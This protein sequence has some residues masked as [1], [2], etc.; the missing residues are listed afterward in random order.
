MSKFQDMFFNTAADVVSARETERTLEQRTQLGD[1]EATGTREAQSSCTMPGDE[2]REPTRAMRS[3]TAAI[4]RGKTGKDFGSPPSKGDK[5]AP[6]FKRTPTGYGVTRGIDLPPEFG[7]R[8]YSRIDPRKYKYDAVRASTYALNF[9][10][11]RDDRMPVEMACEKL[12]QIRARCGVV[13]GQHDDTTVAAFD[14]ALWFCHTVNSASRLNPGRSTFSVPGCTEEF[15]Y[16]D[17]LQILGEDARRFFRTYADDIA[18][19]NR[20]VLSEYDP[21]DIVATERW[22]WLMDVAVR[23]DITK[24]PYLAHDS[25]EACLHLTLS[26]RAALAASK[27]EVLSKVESRQN[28]LDEVFVRKRDVRA[29]R[30]TENWRKF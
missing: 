25:A 11:T 28:D 1:G 13:R 16:L 15:S 18:D 4:T 19:V 27:A 2:V 12:E 8:N 6:E 30:T 29:A 20:R 9:T 7:G 10:V 23:R 3:G 17:I 14:T 22:S 24:Y 26:E 21:Y 5:I